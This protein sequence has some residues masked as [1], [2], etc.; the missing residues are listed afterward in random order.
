MRGMT[1]THKVDLLE[2]EA[3]ARFAEAKQQVVL[4]FLPENLYLARRFIGR[5][6]FRRISTPTGSGRVG[7]P[8]NVT[9]HLSGERASRGACMT[10]DE[11][12]ATSLTGH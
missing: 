9:R 2:R 1:Q 7:R 3:A 5:R 11:S 6:G 8:Y 10:T 12:T 4:A